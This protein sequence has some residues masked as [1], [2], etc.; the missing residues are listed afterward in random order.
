[1][2]GNDVAADYGPQPRPNDVSRAGQ[3]GGFDRGWRDR[4]S[5]L[6]HR[7]TTLMDFFGFFGDLVDN[8]RTGLSYLDDLVDPRTPFRTAQ[9]F[10]RDLRAAGNTIPPVIPD[11][12]I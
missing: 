3:K 6:D 7:H 1:L 9:E 10:G 12:M 4:A 5:P 11:G 2:P 8:F